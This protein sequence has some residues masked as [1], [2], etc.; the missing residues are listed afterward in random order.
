MQ[1]HILRL[2]WGNYN[3]VLDSDV[4]DIAEEIRKY[5][6]THIDENDRLVFASA[7]YQQ[8]K[9]VV[10]DYQ[11]YICNTTYPLSYGLKL[12]SDHI[13]EFI[14]WCPELPQYESWN[15]EKDQ[16]NIQFKFITNQLRYREW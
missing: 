4:Q 3:E 11:D 9:R 13:V 5:S 8:L 7:L 16:Y 14:V 15:I 2:K 10:E 1:R 12:Y 6:I